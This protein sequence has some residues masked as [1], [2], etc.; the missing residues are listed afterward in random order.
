MAIIMAINGNNK[1]QIVIAII[2]IIMARMA[3]IIAIHG[4]RQWQ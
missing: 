4:H 2:A 3:M 1:W